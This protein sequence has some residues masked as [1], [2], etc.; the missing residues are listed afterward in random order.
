MVAAENG[1]AADSRSG[2]VLLQRAGLQAPISGASPSDREP[3]RRI[4]PGW[5][6][7]RIIVHGADIAGSCG[8]RHAPKRVWSGNGA[9][10]RT[11]RGLPVSSSSDFASFGVAMLP[12]VGANRRSSATGKGSVWRKVRSSRV[13]QSTVRLCYEVWRTPRDGAAKTA[14][15]RNAVRLHQPEQCDRYIENYSCHFVRRTSIPPDLCFYRVLEQA[16]QAPPARKMDFTAIVSAGWRAAHRIR[17]PMSTG[18]KIVN[19]KSLL[20]LESET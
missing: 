11:G 14:V 10:N 4:D 19:P 2:G 12:H 17:N 5:R 7:H 1:W 20:A 9:R 18:H 6:W 3:G 16:V 13:S 8:A 15:A